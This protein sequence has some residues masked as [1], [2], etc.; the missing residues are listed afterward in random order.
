MTDWM[1]GAGGSAW[2]ACA[3]TSE[4]SGADSAASA[5]RVFRMMVIGRVLLM[6]LEPS[7]SAAGRRL[8]GGG[9]SGE[10]GTGFAYRGAEGAGAPRRGGTGLFASCSVPFPV[11]AGAG[12]LKGGVS[13]L[14]AARA[15]PVARRDASAV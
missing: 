5:H 1:I 10:T 15:T 14:T 2:A 13:L 11:G 4:P 12:R 9:P 7:R 8:A 6:G 3:A